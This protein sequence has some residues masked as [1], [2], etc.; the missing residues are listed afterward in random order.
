MTSQK[1][2]FLS[3]R[4]FELTLF[5]F[6][7]CPKLPSQDN[8][9]CL[10]IPPVQGQPR[11]SS[12]GNLAYPRPFSPKNH[13]EPWYT[14]NMPLWFKPYWHLIPLNPSNFKAFSLHPSNLKW[15]HRKDHFLSTRSF[16]L[17]LFAFWGCPRLPSQDN[18]VCL[19]IWRNW[20]CKGI[21][22]YSAP[23]GKDLIGMVFLHNQPKCKDYTQTEV[24]SLML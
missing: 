3:T 1:G 21:I 11:L 9:V 4:S 22:T 18:Q 23:I 14:G 20:P 24:L 10:G 15:P 16:E 12:K 8:R 5:S 6:W 7:G 19:G 17:T 13:S 2:I